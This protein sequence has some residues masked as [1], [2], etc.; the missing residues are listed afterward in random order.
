MN[1]T[2]YLSLIFHEK[3]HKCA[4]DLTGGFL[5]KPQSE[6]EMA[7]FASQASTATIQM[8]ERKLIQ[9]SILVDYCL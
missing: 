8:F 5:Q 9:G 3:T 2:Q 1:K 6:I 7:K 4:E